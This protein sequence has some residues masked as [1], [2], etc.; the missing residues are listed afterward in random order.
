MKATDSDLLLSLLHE[1]SPVRGPALLQSEVDAVRMRLRAQYALEQQQ[2]TTAAMAGLTVS[3]AAAAAS[4]PS[5]APA[6]PEK[7]QQV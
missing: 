3:A 4:A 7:Q 6:A 1:A 5:A 2:E